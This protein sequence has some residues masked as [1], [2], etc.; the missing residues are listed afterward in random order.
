M[1]FE[2]PLGAQATTA[3]E[4]N[5]VPVPLPDRGHLPFRFSCR[6]RDRRLQ[7]S[8]EVARRLAHY[9]WRAAEWHFPEFRPMRI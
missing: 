5:R 9:I 1:I 8:T 3:G 6:G 4:E 2:R 7:A